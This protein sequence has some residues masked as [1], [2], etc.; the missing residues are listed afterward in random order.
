[1]SDIGF[2]FHPVHPDELLKDELEYRRSSQKA[3]TKQLGLPHTAFNEILNG[4]NSGQYIQAC[5]S[6]GFL[7]R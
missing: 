1:M 2:V 6:S 4:K 5:N 3:V 7:C